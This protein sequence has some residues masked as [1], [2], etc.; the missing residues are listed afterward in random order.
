MKH[1]K[2][3][4]LPL[5]IMAILISTTVLF[6]CKGRHAADGKRHS[7]LVIHSWGNRAEEG[8]P[9]R[10]MMARAFEEEGL[11]V[12]VHHVYLD[13]I[14][15][16]PE[17]IEMYL[18]PHLADSIENDWQPEVILINDDPAMRWLIEFQSHDYVFQ[19]I[20][21]VFAGINR[22]E[23]DSIKRFPEITGFEDKI[24]MS[25]N[26]D[27]FLKMTG[28]TIA[29]VEIGNN[30]YDNKLRAQIEKQV[31][32]K[33]KHI[34]FL[35]CSDPELNAQE[36]TFS[37]EPMTPDSAIIYGKW[38]LHY[39]YYVAET[40][41]HIQARYNI[42]SNGFIDRSHWAQFT[43]IRE[44][45]NDP[46]HLCFLCGYFT[47]TETQIKDQV[48]YAAE[49]IKG[50]KASSLPIKEH[51]KGYY[52]DYNALARMPKKYDVA[53]LQKTFTV[54]N[55][56]YHLEHPVVF[57]SFV[58]LIAVILLIILSGLAMLVVRWFRSIQLRTLHELELE[59]NVRS[60]LFAETKTTVWTA[61][62]GVITIPK[63]FADAHGVSNVMSTM[64]FDTFVHPETRSAWD[65]LRFHP[66]HIGL[67]RIR[68]CL[69]FNEGKTWEWFEIIFNSTLE[70]ARTWKISGL[71]QNIDDVVAKEKEMREAHQQVS[72]MELKESFL[73]NISHDLRTPLNAVTGFSNL[74]TMPEDEMPLSDEERQGFC[75]IIHQNS[76]MMLTMI[77]SVVDN[78]IEGVAEI[79]MKLLPLSVHNLIEECYRTNA[80]LAPSNLDFKQEHAEPD[81]YISI[82]V[83]R[84]K[85]V[86]N[87]F[88][89][90]AF[91]F[92]TNGS[93]T[94]GW[95]YVDKNGNPPADEEK[96][97]EIYVS[98]TGIGISQT[99]QQHL[100]DRFYKVKEHD[101]G[102]GLGLN[103]SQTIIEKQ[104]GK[105]GVTS[106]LGKGS[107]FWIRL[108]EISK[109]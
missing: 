71:F 1:I 28:D 59:N 78:T 33:I 107:T 105:I 6:S 93:I 40:H 48:H 35:S 86:I 9:F 92:T 47:S 81:T 13:M 52:L 8:K 29:A 84:T 77:N 50:K 43:C 22:L 15:S 41:W 26:I 65:I 63:D 96:W 79:K 82:D 2:G 67:N 31:G 37:G 5:S 103:I 32:D 108:K 61:D 97:V 76:E 109:E 106:E 62:K 80:I 45:F 94:I 69:S 23:R 75:D 12:D 88:I 36:Y 39:L 98:D 74:L 27:I 44:Q 57:W 3:I 95:K 60:L 17:N 99:D 49:I 100:F 104:D 85:Q 25:Q 102:T 34:S 70:T 42:F 54:L 46:Y 21:T 51:A 7:V 10:N 89:S 16:R 11:D 66:D 87:N 30:V 101:K 53:E 58:G 19:R 91:K 18:W 83:H 64:V 56:P 68:L 20:P 90:N 72:D 14:H 4:L 24:E 73:A 55:L 38:A